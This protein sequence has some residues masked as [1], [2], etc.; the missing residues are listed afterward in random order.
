MNRER[1]PDHGRDGLLWWGLLLLFLWGVLFLCTRWEPVVHDGWGHWLWH[2]QNQLTFDSLFSYAES[3]Y[4]HHNPRVGQVITLVLYT[5]GSLHSLVTPVA[6]LG[7]YFLLTMLVLGRRPSMRSSSDALLYATI[8]AMS[9]V[10]VPAFGRML[11]Y[12]PYTGNYLF[13]FA[14]SLVLLVPYRIYMER[15]IQRWW[16]APLLFLLGVVAGLCNEHTGAAFTMLLIAA[17]VGFAR[18]RQLEVW[19]VA[20]AAGLICG[21]TALFVAPGQSLRYEGLATKAS[22][23]ER[24]IDRGVAGNAE[25]VFL[26]VLYSAPLLVWAGLALV[27]RRRDRPPPQSSARM[28]VTLAGAAAALATTMILLA[29]PKTGHRLYFAPVM[30]VVTVT[31]GWVHGQMTSSRWARS[32]LAA[33]AA[34]IILYF[35]F[36][37]VPRYRTLDREFNAR[38]GLIE[39]AAPGS[40]LQL[41]MYSVEAS[42]W[43]T[44]DDLLRP[45]VR[46]RFAEKYGLEAVTLEPARK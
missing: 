15:R 38:M 31:A 32:V 7:L 5:P 3:A 45:R 42:R 16:L 10:T 20:G 35:A 24:V 4:L 46:A 37:C 44:G 30:L 29:S 39:H 43:S 11:F 14:I 6:Q 8:F 28:I 22:L 34:A 26:A 41:P 21:A 33:A 12:R 17:C 25:V 9:A 19:M 13:G 1:A 23:I 27:A 18:K 40:T 2:A 36:A